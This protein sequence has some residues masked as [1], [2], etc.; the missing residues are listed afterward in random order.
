MKT[1]QQQEMKNA[2]YKSGLFLTFAL[3]LSIAATAQEVSKEYHKQYTADANTTL[4]ISN[5]YGDIVV[6]TSDQNQVTIDVKVTV[7][8]PNRERAEK[9]LSY[10]DVQFSEG[11]DEINAKTVIDEKFNFTGWGSGSRKFSIDYTVKMPVKINFTMSNRYGNTEL[12][13]IAGLVDLNIKY[14]NLV[15]DEFTRG[16]EKPLNSLDLAYGKASI[17]SV[18]W[19]DILVRYA[20]NVEIEKSQA[21]LLDSKYSKMELGQTSSL[22]GESRYDNIRIQSINNLVLNSGYSDVVIETLNKKLKFE[23]GYGALTVEQIPA[24]FESIETDTRYI[25]VRLGIDNDASY[26][27]DARLSYG[28]LKFDEAKFQNQRHIVQN[29]STETTGIVGTESA[30]GSKVKVNASYGSVRLE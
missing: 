24:G 9:L 10:I 7:E 14:G 5:K 12:E 21:L 11:G 28:D 8:L 4:N 20:G 1:K 16:N 25:G 17:A 22:V 23:G 27:L 19:L 3:I 2:T 18:G 13:E 29:N 30:P 6:E 26:N 15:A